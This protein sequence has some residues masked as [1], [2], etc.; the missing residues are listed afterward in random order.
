MS[1]WI[2]ALRI[3]ALVGALAG[4]ACASASALEE[5]QRALASAQTELTATNEGLSAAAQQLKSLE[6][7]LAEAQGTMEEVQRGLTGRLTGMA[8]EQGAL[9]E[10]LTGAQRALTGVQEEIGRVSAEVATLN[11]LM[12]ARTGDLTSIE[13]ELSVLA[14]RF[15]DLK[16]PFLLARSDV[17]ENKEEV[18]RVADRMVELRAGEKRI[19]ESLRLTLISDLYDILIFSNTEE[20]ANL[21]VAALTRAVARIRSPRLRSRWDALATVVLDRFTEVYAS[22]EEWNDAFAREEDAF[23]AILREHQMTA[24]IVER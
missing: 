13:K 1:Q 24:R 15:A 5:T 8:D 2:R 19:E 22:E 12:E 9:R 18:A 14:T 20:E 7:R 17:G 3:L 11:E 6:E 4:A 21:T 23:L 16:E 10:A